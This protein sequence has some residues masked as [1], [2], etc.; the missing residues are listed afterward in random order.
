MTQREEKL[1]CEI[2]DNHE[3]ATMFL[4]MEYAF[5]NNTSGEFKKFYELLHETQMTYAKKWL[6]ALEELT[7]KDLEGLYK[8]AGMD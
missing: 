7:G 4:F 6:N 5:E 8:S 3:N 1:L 2:L